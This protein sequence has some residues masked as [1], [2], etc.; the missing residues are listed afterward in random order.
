MVDDKGEIYHHTRG[1][2]LAVGAGI[3]LIGRHTVVGK[4]LI[5]AI[6]VDDDASA[7]AFKWWGDIIP[8]THKPKVVILVLA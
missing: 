2:A 5:V 7:G 8:T 3:G 6:A 4:K 1:V